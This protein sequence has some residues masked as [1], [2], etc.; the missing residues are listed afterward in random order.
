LIER[1]PDAR[2]TDAGHASVL[3]DTTPATGTLDAAASGLTAQEALLLWE[4]TL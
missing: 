4:R 2:Y 3:D 1:Q